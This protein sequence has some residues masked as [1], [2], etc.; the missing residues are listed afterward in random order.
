V[1]SASVRYPGNTAGTRKAHSTRDIAPQSVQRPIPKLRP[2]VYIRYS[3]ITVNCATPP[4]PNHTRC[5]LPERR[6]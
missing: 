4:I 6:F 5:P 2:L 3:A 1:L